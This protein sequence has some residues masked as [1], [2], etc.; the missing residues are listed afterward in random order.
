VGAAVAATTRVAVGAGG[1][2]VGASVGG[3]AV[4]VAGG[5]GVAVGVGGAQLAS[6]LPPAIANV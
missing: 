5:S 2:A 1:V 6:A 3:N 4:A